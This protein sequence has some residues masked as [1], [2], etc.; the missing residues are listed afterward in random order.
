MSIKKY[1]LKKYFILSNVQ[2]ISM[3]KFYCCNTPINAQ[4][5]KYDNLYLYASNKGHLSG[6]HK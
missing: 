3:P 4:I 6:F 5:F 1:F 2:L